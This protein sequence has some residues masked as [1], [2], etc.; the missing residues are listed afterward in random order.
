MIKWV[1]SVVGSVVAGVI[2][3][4]L[5][6]VIHKQPSTAVNSEES[7][8]YLGTNEV[9]GQYLMD[10]LTH[11]AIVITQLSDTNYRIE[12]PSGSWPWEGTARLDGD[13][14]YGE[15]RFINSLASMKVKGSLRSDGSIAV[16]YTFTTDSEGKPAGGRMDNHVW[17]P[18]KP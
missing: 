10:N 6:Q 12:E 1:T 18:T 15:A 4:L 13:A 3:F 2:V 7:S 16:Q 14:I 5:T 17:Y 9:S 11:R 8:S